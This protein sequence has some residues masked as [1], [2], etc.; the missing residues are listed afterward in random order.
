VTIL[1]RS[2]SAGLV[3]FALLPPAGAAVVSLQPAAPLRGRVLDETGRPAG[4]LA[5]SYYPGGLESATGPDGSFVIEATPEPFL[6]GEV[7]IATR[8]RS[9]LLRLPACRF[10]EAP[11]GAIRMPIRG[12]EGRV[13]EDDGTPAEGARVYAGRSSLPD[14]RWVEPD[15]V[16]DRDGRFTLFARAGSLPERLFIATERGMRDAI[17]VVAGGEPLFVHLERTR[18]VRVTAIGPDGRPA[19]FASL[20]LHHAGTDASHRFLSDAR[21]RFRLDGVWTRERT[22][23]SVHD[24]SLSWLCNEDL[25]EGEDDLDLVVRLDRSTPERTLAGRVVF[26]DGRP[27]RRAWVVVKST[28]ASEYDYRQTTTDED[29]RFL[30]PYPPAPSLSIAVS[31]GSASGSSTP[32]GGVRFPGRTVFVETGVEEVPPIVV[33]GAPFV[34]GTV[35]DEHGR[36]LA[37]VACRLF[38]PVL[39]GGAPFTAGPS[40]APSRHE[41]TGTT[42]ARG[43]YRI[44]VPREGLYHGRFSAGGHEAVEWMISTGRQG[45]VV[46][47]PSAAVTGVVRDASGRPVPGVPLSF[48]WNER[49]PHD[50]EMVRTDIT[51]RFEC[52]VTPGSRVRIEVRDGLYDAPPVTVTSPSD[53]AILLRSR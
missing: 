28:R 18:V 12:I 30:V 43:Y 44:G 20:S 19:P 25:P 38:V 32:R 45:R 36:R 3:G 11:G 8:A 52:F 34:H 48:E 4:G 21:G 24:L 39:T 7:S 10:P 40:A 13:V 50:S 37:G 6:A 23:I 53:V 33:A 9:G 16:A 42:D 31:D 22:W 2:A 27:C 46:F 26:R 15:T 49:S 5:V 1:A 14:L 35:I 17:C 47:D 41:L 51:G 29:G